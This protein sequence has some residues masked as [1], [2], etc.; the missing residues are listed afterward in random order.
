[1]T[2]TEL[3]EKDII[4]KLPQVPYVID[5]VGAAIEWAKEVHT[6][7]DYHKNIKFASEVTDFAC[8]ISEPNFFK[9]HLVVGA[10]L[11]DIENAAQ[12]P[13]FEIFKTASKS[14]EKT[15]D[16]LVINKDLA[17]T[18]G[19]FNALSIHLVQLAQKD[20]E[21]FCVSLMSIL[22]DLKEI[23]SGMK[24]AEVKAPITPSDYIKVL[25][26]AFVVQNIKLANLS[27]SNKVKDIFNRVNISL[28]N[29]FIY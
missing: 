15:L 18:R 8:S 12:D 4:S 9:V 29:D 22:N 27:L 16:K 23:A 20:E 10:L 5:Q 13:K 28:N 17:E 26:Y 1:M 25:G 7:G 3:F 2:E 19:C 11:M 6:E 21:C 24:E 14:V